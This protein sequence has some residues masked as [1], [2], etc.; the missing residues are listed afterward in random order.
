MVNSITVEVNLHIIVYNFAYLVLNIEHKNVQTVNFSTNC[1]RI[2]L[3][4]D[5]IEFKSDETGTPRRS[6]KYTTAWS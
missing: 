3:S 1:E 5:E 6:N 4:W 2:G